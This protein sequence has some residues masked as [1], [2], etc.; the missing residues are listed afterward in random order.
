MTD[1]EF[2]TW[3]A[4]RL[5]HVHGD[6]EHIDFVLKLRRMAAVLPQEAGAPPAEIPMTF[7]SVTAPR[8]AYLLTELERVRAERD[9]ARADAARFEEALAAMSRH[10]AAQAF[11]ADKLRAEVSRLQ[12]ALRELTARYGRPAAES[13]GP[14]L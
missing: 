14:F 5:V 7:P 10:A 6:P 4:D 13:G 9:A 2:L 12:E 3:V 8:I 11:E 1:S